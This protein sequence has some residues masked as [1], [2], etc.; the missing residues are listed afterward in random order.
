L[1]GACGYTFG[2]TCHSRL[3]QFHDSHLALPRIE[4]QGHDGLQEFAA[5]L[6]MVG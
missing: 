6:G 5:K 3:S 2:L 4:I 1:V